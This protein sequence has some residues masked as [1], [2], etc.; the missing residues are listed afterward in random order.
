MPASALASGWTGQIFDLPVVC[1]PSYTSRRYSSSVLAVSL[2]VVLALPDLVALELALRKLGPS[3][4]VLAPSV[5]PVLALVVHPQTRA[6]AFVTRLWER[7][8]GGGTRIGA[9]ETWRGGIAPCL[10][11][12]PP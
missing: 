8:A 10:S 11:V 12:G 1:L 7:G 3:L 9:I 4:P 6:L 5:F 2:A